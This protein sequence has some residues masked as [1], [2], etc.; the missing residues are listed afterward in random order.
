ML[1]DRG[2]LVRDGDRYQ[3]SGAVEALAV[4]ETLHALVAARL[5]GL[6]PAERRLLCDA[7]VLGKSFT[8]SG[9]AAISNLPAA[10]LDPLVESL[11]RKEI[12]TL[13]SD[14]LSPERGQLAFVQDLLRRVTYETISKRERKQRHLAAAAHMRAEP[15][16]DEELAGIVASHYL[17]AYRAG[18]NDADADELLE[19][20]SI[21]VGARRRSRSVA[22]SRRR[23]GGLLPARGAELSGDSARAGRLVGASWEMPSVQAG[24]FQAAIEQG[25]SEPCCCGRRYERQARRRACIGRDGGSDAIRRAG[26]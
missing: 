2:V 9:L 18:E 1:L 5:D 23:G 26:P 11:V 24:E 22:G 12:L 6:T 17:D 14:R 21:D 25:S 15:A 10:D 8:S 19:P 4:P 16:G 13:Q 3:V 7:A 20:R